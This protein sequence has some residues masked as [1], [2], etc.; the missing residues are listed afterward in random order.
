MN[1]INLSCLLV[2]CLPVS[3]AYVMGPDDRVEVSEAQTEIAAIRQTGMIRIYGE[4][5]VSGLLTG[6]N[7]DVV[8]S[9]GHAAIYWQDLA[10]KGWRKGEL[11]AQ[12]RFR[13]NLDPG[14]GGEWQS[15]RLVASGYSLA[16]NV[17]KDEYDWSIFRTSRA[18]AADC[19]ILHIMHDGLACKSNLLM[20][21]FHFDRPDIKLLDQSCKVKQRKDSGIIVHDC[22]TKDGSSGA[23]LFC[24]DGGKLSLLAINISGLTNRDYFDGGVYGK[25]GRA[26]NDRK[27]KNI[28]IS[29]GGEFYQALVEEMKASAERRFLKEY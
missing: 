22:D 27:H 20:S 8:I 29:V 16:E 3:F 23:P 12:G 5:F 18:V 4:E 19:K 1:R 7:C 24:Q 21:G 13:F 17:G 9:A 6:G 2:L 15:M 25:S 10:R 26:F 11:R 28:A 14:A